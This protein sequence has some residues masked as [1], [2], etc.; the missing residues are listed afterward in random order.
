MKSIQ[1]KY[2]NRFLLHFRRRQKSLQFITTEMILII[3][4]HQA[5]GESTSVNPSVFS[6]QLRRIA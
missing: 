6:E 2:G 4:R 1:G 5:N 3:L